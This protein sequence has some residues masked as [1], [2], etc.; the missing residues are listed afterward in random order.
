MAFYF[1]VCTP[2]SRTCCNALQGLAHLEEQH[3]IHGD[4]KPANLLR[5][6]DGRIKLADFGSALT[7]AAGCGGGRWE[8]PVNGTPAFRAP[9]TL[10]QPSRL[11]AQALNP[12]PYVSALVAVSL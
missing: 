11:S 6:G 1:T 10:Q 4:L 9:E 3:V 5:A 12:K 7:Y 2:G 8:G